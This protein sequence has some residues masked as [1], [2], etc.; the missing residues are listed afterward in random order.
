MTFLPTGWLYTLLGW[1]CL[2]FA[3][4]HFLCWTLPKCAWLYYTGRI[5]PCDPEHWTDTNKEGKF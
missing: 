1:L 4:V 5:T 2:S 3:C